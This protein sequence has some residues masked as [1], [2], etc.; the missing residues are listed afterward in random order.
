[1]VIAIA[2]PVAD[3][4]WDLNAY[5]KVAD[6]LFLMAYDEHSEPGNPGPIA[7]QPWF[8]DSVARAVRG[9]PLEKVVVALGS[10]AYDWEKGGDTIPHSIEDVWLTA[11]ESGITPRFDRSSAN[12]YFVYEEGGV[13]HDIWLLD[14]ASMEQAVFSAA[15]YSRLEAFTAALASA[16]WLPPA[17][18]LF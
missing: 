9:L 14:A 7:S 13:R 3:P 1:M 18:P 2:V 16:E 4:E 8:A 5:A 17:S 11:R 6:R 15:V 10:Y 12:S